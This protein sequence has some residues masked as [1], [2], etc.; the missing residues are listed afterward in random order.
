MFN[1][2]HGSGNAI[3]E[4]RKVDDF[5]KID[6][7]G[8]YKITL[9]QDSSLSLKITADDNVMKYIRTT[10]DGDKLRISTKKNICAKKAIEIVIGVRNLDGLKGSGAIEMASNG[11]LNVKDLAIQLSGASKVNLDLNATSV[12]TKGTGATEI[13][14]KGQAASHTVNLTGSG[15]VYALDFVVGKYD[16]ET[17]GASECKINVLTDLNVHT[18]GASEIEYRGNP[19]NVNTSKAGASSVKKID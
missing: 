17:T 8:G 3:T 11:K 13:N 6:V 4:D 14:L 12:T 9:K 15:K 2:V 16:I 19:T 10:V 1:C 18:T 5:T 7:S